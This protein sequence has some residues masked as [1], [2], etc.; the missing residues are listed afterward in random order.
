MKLE[1]IVA[2]HTRWIGKVV[3][4]GE[5]E[6]EILTI[7]NTS[8]DRRRRSSLITSIVNGQWNECSPS[9]LHPRT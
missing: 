2:S 8:C 5:R 3:C 7:V 9:S 4:P 1:E 6:V